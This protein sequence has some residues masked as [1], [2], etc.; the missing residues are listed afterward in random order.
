MSADQR[1][2]ILSGL[3]VLPCGGEQRKP[4][5]I[6]WVQQ[7]KPDRRA[8]AS[9]RVPGG[10]VTF[11]EFNNGFQNVT[12]QLDNGSICLGSAQALK[13]M[14]LICGAQGARYELSR[15]EGEPAFLLEWVT[16]HPL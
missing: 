7:Q 15:K 3:M 9:A 5:P 1:T 13:Q 10:T 14:F 16:E 4:V 2:P 12:F 11:V 6:P 8:A